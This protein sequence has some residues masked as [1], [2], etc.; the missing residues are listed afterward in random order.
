MSFQPNANDQL[1]I[2]GVTYRIAEHPAA[3]GMPYGQE[4]RQAIVYR[5]TPSPVGTGEGRGESAR[6]L[7]VFKPR[8]RVPAMVSLSDKLDAFADL[9][10]LQVCRRTVLSARR[11]GDLLR[12][13]PDLTYAVLMPWID[14]PTWFDVMFDK[15]AL[16]RN[17]SLQLAHGL[18]EALAAME[19]RGV[20]HGDL[21]APNVLIPALAQG[22]IHNSPLASRPAPF[23]LEL[24]DVEQLYAPGLDRPDA[25]PG[26]SPGYAHQTAR[27]GL[28]G[29]KVDRF[30][31]AVLLVEMLGW[32]DERVR[33]AAWGESYFEPDE[34]Q[35]ATERYQ[36]LARVLRE[37]WGNGVANLFERAWRSDT[38]DDC[39]TFGEWLVALPAQRFQSQPVAPPPRAQDALLAR[40]QE[41]EQRGDL[42]GA[43]ETYHQLL[44]R[45]PQSDLLRAELAQ[46]VA[47]LENETRDAQQIRDWILQADALARSKNWAQAATAYRTLI[48]QAPADP[49]AGQ[50]RAALEVC[51]D[52]AELARMFDDGV[53]ALQRGDKPAAR[54]LLVAVQRRRAGY[55]RGGVQAVTWLA[56]ASQEEHSPVNRFRLLVA[57]TLLAFLFVCG[58]ALAVFY[59]SSPIYL[60]LLAT[61]TP[62]PTFTAA[63]TYTPQ[64]TATPVII[65]VT[66]TLI[67]QTSTPTA[68]ALPRAGDT[69]TFAPDNAP[70]QFVPAGEFTMGSDSGDSDEKPVHTVYL[71]AFWMDKYE[72]T[73]ALYATCVNA[74][75]CS[76]PSETKSYTRSA[77]FGNTQYNNYPVIYVD[78]NQAK[79]YC[80][81]AGKRLPTEAEWEKAARGTDGRVYPWGNSFDGTRLNFC[82][83]N[84]P[85]DW[86]D[87]NSDDGYADTSP[88]GN[89]A[90]GAS[91]YGIMDLSGNV[92]EWVADWYGSYPSSLQRNPWGANSGQERVLRGGAWLNISGSARAALRSLDE[93]TNFGNNV[94]F[95]CARSP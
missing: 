73:N 59:P 23:P 14:G 84:C 36:V 63:P 34:L 52:E 66:A 87:N 49:Q 20:A 68:T 80:E 43:L 29:A 8:F 12:A 6:A 47:R 70:M 82:D 31:G 40:A 75:K 18:A 35:Q 65:V 1:H 56:K 54:E 58:I 9:P 28:W 76:R 38:L 48:A 50:W 93:P 13:Y 24:V 92:W 22:A 3:P 60:S 41:L 27:D 26:G 69:R 83:K 78:W 72:V 94:G 67:P 86:R 17:Q 88:V 2:D 77:Y 85:F 21:S 95:R 51:E 7:K 32:G 10:G 57:G 44:A 74:G 16:T 62:T 5:L 81:W 25:L 90:R 71:D 79:Q 37:A 91:P 61:R 45:L 53:T 42:A 64:P 30:A 55:A 39:P 33:A 15:R 46:I 89:Y 19:E 4:G 11:Y